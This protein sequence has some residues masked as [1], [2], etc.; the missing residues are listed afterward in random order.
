MNTSYYLAI[1]VRLFSIGLFLYSLQQSSLIV[2]VLL[3]GSINGAAISIFF[4]L[5]TSVIPMI[6]A[7]LL[8]LFPLLVSKA[9]IKSE[10]DKRVE[11][12]S[13]H[14]LL[15]VFVLVIGLYCFYYAITDSVYWATL[16]KMSTNSH[17]SEIPIGLSIESKANM[18]ATGIQLL[19][20][21]MLV[22]K[23]RTISSFLLRITQ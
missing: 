5:A 3:E 1:A 19:L 21:I 15:T 16:W 13:I 18:V 2:E 8:W 10:F 4:I 7:I 9:I 12:I 11:L 20:S 23:A 17:Y 22:V 6:I 14:K